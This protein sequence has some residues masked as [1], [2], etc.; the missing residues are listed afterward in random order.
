VIQRVYPDLVVAAVS[1][2]ASGQ[3][4]RSIT[5]KASV[6]NVGEVN[7][8]FFSVFF[9][10]SKDE[11]IGSDDI[12]LGNVNVISLGAGMEQALEA[13]ARVPEG[14]NGGTYYLGALADFP[15]KVKE[16]NETN[17]TAVGTRIVVQS[18]LPDLVFTSLSSIDGV[19]AG[20]DVSVLW[21]VTNAGSL[22]VGPFTMTV[23][24]SSDSLI[25]SDDIAI[26]TSALGS[27]QSG[28]ERHFIVTCVV[29]RALP[30]GVYYI[31]AI[32][33][34]ATG[35]QSGAVL[36]NVWPASE[37]MDCSLIRDLINSYYMNVLDRDPDQGGLDFWTAEV[38]R[39]VSL[40]IDTGEGFQALG[41]LFFNS[42]EYR[43]KEKF[44]DEFVTDLYET[45][46]NRLPD[47]QGK[48]HWAAQLRSG[49]TRDML[50]TEFANSEEFALYLHGRVGT[51][52]TRPENNLLN[53]LYR[54]FLG[55]LQDS[56]GFNHWLGQM[57]AA[58]CS[59]ATAV[60]NLTYQIAQAFVRSTEYTNRKRNN[61][62]YVEDLYNGILKRGADPAGY[63]YWTTRLGT[64]TSVPQRLLVLTEFT[65]STEF[66]TRVQEIISAGCVAR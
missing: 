22:G 19:A 12:P 2:P 53:D 25:T 35:A 3:T 56:A 15:D 40:G 1:G 63:R 29:P 18:A 50:I 47:E 16:S 26:G 45:F 41:R 54:G 7:A 30:A 49:L 65:K 37:G 23:Y 17:N 38:E 28:E 58:Q 9:Y 44:D 48:A 55:R 11:V 34:P 31:G 46:L 6:Q 52:S 27:L 13:T 62:Q 61:S 4:G 59:G 43:S 8:P 66:Q 24:L 51:M 10:L 14:I 32:A 57:Q 33:D 20:S 42:T 39:V 5:V 64:L 36:L 21:K 60:R